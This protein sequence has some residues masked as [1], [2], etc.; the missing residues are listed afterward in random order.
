MIPPLVLIIQY[1]IPDSF[2]KGHRKFLLTAVKIREQKTTAAMKRSLMRVL[3]PER[4]NC[5]LLT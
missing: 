5:L 1:N 2:M 4:A 3:R